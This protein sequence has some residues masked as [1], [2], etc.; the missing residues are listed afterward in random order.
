MAT[1][2]YSPRLGFQSRR[3]N[4]VDRI[5]KYIK[6]RIQPLL[7]FIWSW[8]RNERGNA[9]YV[10]IS[11]HQLF[12]KPFEIIV[13]FR[14]LRTT[15]T[16]LIKVPKNLGAGYVP[17]CLVRFSLES[18]VSAICYR[19]Y[20]KCIGRTSNLYFV[21]REYK[22]LLF[23]LRD[24]S[25]GCGIWPLIERKECKLRVFENRVLRKCEPKKQ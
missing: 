16:K 4:L 22:I 17:Y 3:N 12:N 13:T 6:G 2:I 24:F 7:E 18:L 9:R 11:C 5:Q 21:V 19:K 14:Y 15:A 25:C 20:Y 10:F 8:P 23:C 1:R